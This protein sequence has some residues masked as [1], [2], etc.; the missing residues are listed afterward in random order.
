MPLHHGRREGRRI[1]R[2]LTEWDELCG[3]TGTGRSIMSLLVVVD[4]DDR[5]LQFCG[6]RLPMRSLTS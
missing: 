6:F 3:D 5:D 4:A 2:R 1:D